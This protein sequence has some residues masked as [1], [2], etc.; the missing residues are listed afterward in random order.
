MSSAWAPKA[1]CSP[2]Q[3]S[4]T[5]GCRLPCG[6]SAAGPCAGWGRSPRAL[7]ELGF[8]TQHEHLSAS[9]T[10]AGTRPSGDLCLLIRGLREPGA[11]PALTLSLGRVG[12]GCW[13]GA[14]GGLGGRSGRSS[15]GASASSRSCGCCT[16]TARGAPGGCWA[17]WSSSTARWVLRG[18]TGSGPV[19]PPCRA[20][21]VSP[22]PSCGM[23]QEAEMQLRKG[24]GKLR[25]TAGR[26]ANSS[27]KAQSPRGQRFASSV[28]ET[29]GRWAGRW[30]VRPGRWLQ[31]CEAQPACL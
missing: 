10:Q 12:E 29:G 19:S 11:T 14:Q 9:G 27:Q 5:R 16:S 1:R 7:T 23:G 8:K 26:V 6:L 30:G 20:D 15:A 3:P 13:R 24:S 4:G 21:R 28:G 17:P 31:G 18:R 22:C 25:S 2:P